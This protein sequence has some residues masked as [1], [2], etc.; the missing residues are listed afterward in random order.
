MHTRRDFSNIEL[1]AVF[2]IDAAK[3]LVSSC[4]DR[5][6]EGGREGGLREGTAVRGDPGVKNV[7][8][9]GIFVVRLDDRCR[10]IYAGHSS[11]YNQ[12]GARA[13]RA[14]VR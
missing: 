9:A 7:E 12:L 8:R 2:N 5:A 4:I 10:S 11:S 14:L 6:R 1:T 3:T 13:S